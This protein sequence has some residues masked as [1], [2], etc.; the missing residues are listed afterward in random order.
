M[1]LHTPGHTPD[2]LSLW[3][4]AE[5]RIFVGDFIYPWTAIHL[6]CLGANVLQYLASLRKLKRF[7]AD[8][9]A[10]LLAVKADAAPPAVTAVPDATGASPPTAA[11]LVPPAAVDSS[12]PDVPE[13]HDDKRTRTQLSLFAD[14]TPAQGGWIFCF[15]FFILLLL[16]L[17][18][19]FG[20]NSPF[21]S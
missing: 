16:L 2:S 14:C 7:V 21:L 17:L 1:V 13:T 10:R 18:L 6:D 9:D 3:F 15:Y 8:Q 11:V 4:P 12:V 20:H 5:R 19:L